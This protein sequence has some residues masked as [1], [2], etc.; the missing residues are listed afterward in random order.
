MNKKQRVKN[1]KTA[2]WLYNQVRQ[3][4]KCINCGQ[5]TFSGHFVPP[6]F[7]DEGFWICDRVKNENQTES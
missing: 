7:G 2:E 5:D 6:C 4:W 1:R 3:P